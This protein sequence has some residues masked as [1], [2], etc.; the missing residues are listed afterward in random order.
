MYVHFRNTCTKFVC[1]GLCQQTQKLNTKGGPCCPTLLHGTRLLLLERQVSINWYYDPINIS[2][3]SVT[4][5]C[6]RSYY[7]SINYGSGNVWVLVKFDY[8]PE[9]IALPRQFH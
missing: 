8:G 1:L 7:H 5:N 2:M 4:I 9:G 6:I 3:L